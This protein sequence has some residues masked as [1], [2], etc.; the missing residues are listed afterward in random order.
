MSPVTCAGALA[1]VKYL[2]A[3]NELR[4]QHQD[5][6]RKLKYRLDKAGLPVMTC[7]TTHIVPVLVGEAKRCKAMSD[8]LLNE[9]GIY[10]QPINYP[11]V[12]VGTE[13]LRFAPT[14]F[15]DDGMIEDLITALTAS[16]ACHPAQ[17]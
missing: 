17:A 5:R 7:S 8:Y 13:R 14:P 15:H 16:F 4:E 6:A 1:A 3:N 9:H 2:K 12:D 11:T 10:V